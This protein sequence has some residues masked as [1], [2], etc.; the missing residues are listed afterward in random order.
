M[1][2][3]NKPHLKQLLSV[4]FTD[5]ERH[6]AQLIVKVGFWVIAPVYLFSMFAYPF[7]ASGWTWK[8]VH[9]VWY[10]WQALNVGM[11][12]LVSS[13]IAFRAAK[14]YS[15][16]QR[17]RDFRAAQA[18]L[19]AALSEL[20]AYFKSCAAVLREAWDTRPRVGDDE[21]E[22][23]EAMELH[24][25][26]PE[27]PASHKETFAQCI[28]YA[29]P[30]VGDFLA[31]VLAELQVHNA[32]LAS[33][34]PGHGQRGGVIHSG[35][36]VLSYM[37]ALGLLQARLNRLFSFARNEEQ[38]DNSPLQ[39]DDLLNAYRNLDLRPGDYS[40]KHM[41]TLAAFSQRWIDRHKSTPF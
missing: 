33:L 1:E 2:P 13:A 34:A 7:V 29:R 18:F 28:R 40:H 10:D 15:E 24:H 32:R 26:A 3:K 14:F 12:A 16:D 17:K 30:D 22:G 9:Q 36:T 35:D 11:L 25:A 6:I 5:L 37:F 19:P 21:V 39:G 8:E 23:A 31:K 27:L 41:G 4:P 20:T 38:F